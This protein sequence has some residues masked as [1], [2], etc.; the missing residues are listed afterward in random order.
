MF[1][2]SKELGKS[3]CNGSSPSRRLSLIIALSLVVGSLVSS[4]TAVKSSLG[5]RGGNESLLGIENKTSYFIE[6]EHS[7][8]SQSLEDI[9]WG[10]TSVV[11]GT[12]EA[13]HCYEQGVRI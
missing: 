7:G 8:I 5:D 6:R 1:L 3:E 9:V 4:D 10:N 11:N 13:A 12:Y 2:N